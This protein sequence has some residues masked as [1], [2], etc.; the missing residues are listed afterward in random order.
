MSK[1]AEVGVVQ[2]GGMGPAW[3]S[4][5]RAAQSGDREAFRELYTRFAPMVHAVAL[6]SVDCH[7]ADDVTQEVFLGAWRSLAD[8]REPSRFGGWLASMARRRAL[9]VATSSARKRERSSGTAAEV[10]ATAGFG[11]AKIAAGSDRTGPHPLGSAT[12]RATATDSPT[13]DEVLTHL[14]AL[15]EALR[16]P[17]TLRLVE[18]LS[19]IEIATLL[20][21]PPGSVRVSLHRGMQKLRERLGVAPSTSPPGPG[22]ES[23]PTSSTKPGGH[24]TPP[25]STAPNHSAP[26]A[27]STPRPERSK[28]SDQ[29]GPNRSQA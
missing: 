28:P 11:I 15:P 20:D 19:G 17:L 9:R 18:G 26:S 29:P 16:M 5:V 24:T 7:A 2:D 27:D 13:I 14:A 21:R 23:S 12:E 22:N 10:E 4:Q 8:L 25:D 3:T 1:V 6:G